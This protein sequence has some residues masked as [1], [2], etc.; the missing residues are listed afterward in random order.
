MVL[1]FTHVLAP[2]VVLAQPEQHWQTLLS[3]AYDGSLSGEWRSPVS[4]ITALPL[5]ERKAIAHRAMLEID[6]PH[7]IINLG[8][9]MPEVRA[10]RRWTRTLP[11]IV[12]QRGVSEEMAFRRTILSWPAP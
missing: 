5:N 4:H 10:R 6:R 9:G 12:Q 7:E 8:I 11:G 1:Y 2:Q 3:P